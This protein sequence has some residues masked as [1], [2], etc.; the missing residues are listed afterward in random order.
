MNNQSYTRRINERVRRRRRRA[1]VLT[2]FF[3]VILLLA[4]LS[5]FLVL[6]FTGRLGDGDD[7]SVTTEPPT[8]TQAPAES[9]E[10]AGSETTAAPETTAPPAET[11]APPV[12]YTTLTLTRADMAKGDLILVSADYPYVFPATEGH[13]TLTYGNKSKGYQLGSAQDKLD[14]RVLAAF[15]TAADSFLAE[16]G[17]TGLILVQNGAYRSYAAQEDLYNRRVAKEGEEAAAK[18]VALPGNSEHHTG[19]AMDLSVYTDGKM[20]GLDELETYQWVP[21]NFPR[22]G[23]V[24]RYPASKIAITGIAYEPWHFRYVG[25]PHAVYMTNN[26]LCLEEYINTLRAYQADG[27]HL[28]VESDGIT[29]EIWYVPLTDGEVTYALVPDGVPY[30]ISGNNRDGFVV[31]L[32]LGRQ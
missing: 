18:Y 21:K 15:N 1:A 32:T 26:N 11:T 22:Y 3:I 20:Y 12:T 17:E 29:Y 5:V 4:L 8:Q 14:T 30:S 10:P 6:H 2:V 19:L 28:F 25:I 23:F 24:L 31:T 7:S 9:G 13:L 27:T 16:T